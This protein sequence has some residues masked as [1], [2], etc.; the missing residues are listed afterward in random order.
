M[1]I[2]IVFGIVGANSKSR[3]MD[4]FLTYIYLSEHIIHIYKYSNILSS[5]F[6]NLIEIIT[7][8]Q[9]VH[10]TKQNNTTGTQ[11]K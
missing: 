5:Y 1:I 7:T 11:K 8:G 10:Q 4:F 6:C 2:C 9:Y 3:R